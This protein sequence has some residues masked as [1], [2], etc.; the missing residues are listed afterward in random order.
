MFHHHSPWTT[1]HY[2]WPS[3]V[4]IFRNHSPFTTIHHLWP[5]WVAIFHHHSPRTLSS[6]KILSHHLSSSFT[7]NHHPPSLITIFLEP[8]KSPVFIIIHYSP[9]NIAYNIMLPVPGQAWKFPGSSRCPSGPKAKVDGGSALAAT[10]WP[11]S[12]GTHGRMCTQ[13]GNE[14]KRT[15]E[16]QYVDDVSTDFNWMKMGRNQRNNMKLGGF[17]GWSF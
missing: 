13:K 12:N 3:P 8:Q 14:W 17:T 16:F 15:E 10:P 7:M 5:S 1:I 6:L 9:W 2:H 4:T 11:R